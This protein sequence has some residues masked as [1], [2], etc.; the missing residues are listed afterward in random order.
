[1]AFLCSLFMQRLYDD[2]DYF[3]PKQRTKL[4][5]LIGMNIIGQVKYGTSV[6]H[7][8]WILMS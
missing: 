6:L 5:L 7:T 8:H 2:L 3:L 4:D 1:M